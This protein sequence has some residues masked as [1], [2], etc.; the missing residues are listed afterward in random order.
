MFFIL[1]AV[2]MERA[3]QNAMHLSKLCDGFLDKMQNYRNQRYALSGVLKEQAPA[4]A[5]AVSILHT[6]QVFK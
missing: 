1:T 5:Q 4:V 2:D 3:K 6:F